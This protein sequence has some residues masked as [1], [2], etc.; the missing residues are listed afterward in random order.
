MKTRLV[1]A[2]L[3]LGGCP[4]PNDPPPPPTPVPL[5]NMDDFTR[6][7]D[8]SVDWFADQ[9]PVEAICDDFGWTYDPLY[10]SLAVGTDICDYPTFTQPTLEPLEPGDVIDIQGLHGPLTADEPAEGYLAIAIEGEILWE[11]TVAIPANAA[12]IQDQV[13]IEK[14]F[15]VGAELQFHLHNHGPNGW[16]LMEVMVTHAQ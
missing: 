5:V 13:T 9:R 3:V 8:P 15:P 4:T 11:W 14:S 6:V 1:G 12:V 2:A 7:T 10:M 16:D